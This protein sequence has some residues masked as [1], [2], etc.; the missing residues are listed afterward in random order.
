[1]FYNVL[2]YIKMKKIIWLLLLALVSIVPLFTHASWDMNRNP[3]II[4]SSIVWKM[5]KLF[6]SIGMDVNRDFNLLMEVHGLVDY[7]KTSLGRNRLYR[8]LKKYEI[9]SYLMSLPWNRLPHVDCKVWKYDKLNHR[10]YTEIASVVPHYNTIKT[11]SLT[12]IPWK[13]FTVGSGD[14]DKAFDNCQGSTVGKDDKTAGCALR[15]RHYFN[16]SAFEILS[17]K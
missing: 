13:V 5:N 3:V 2:L 16:T 12:Q 4:K 17:C 7:R 9:N 1:M 6:Y 11:Y 10:F 15:M 14:I 8:S